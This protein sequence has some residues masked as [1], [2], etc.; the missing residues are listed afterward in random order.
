MK[1][2]VEAEAAV[3]LA[4]LFQLSASV[5]ALR[6]I[7]TSGRAPAWIL[8]ASALMAMALRRCISLYGIAFGTSVDNLNLGY[9]V[10]GLLISI[11]M[12]AGVLLI[13]P[14]FVSI[15]ETSA[16]LAN[17]E[18]KYRD[19]LESSL[20]GI[21]A[22]NPNNGELLEANR[23]FA[24]MV[25]CPPASLLGRNVFD[26]VE[27]FGR[28]PEDI[29]SRVMGEGKFRFGETVLKKADGSKLI[30][31]VSAVAVEEEEGSIVYA[32]LH[33]LTER[34][35]AEEA[36][37]KLIGQLKDALSNVKRLSGLLPICA[38]CKKIR[39]DKGYWRQ[40]EQYIAEHSE[41]DFTHGLCPQCIKELYSDLDKGGLN[42]RSPNSSGEV[43]DKEA[44][45]SSE[46]GFSVG[47]RGPTRD[48]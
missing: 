8:I 25:G 30:I 16:R 27:L 48:K 11:L 41:A 44:E 19:V 17:S 38:S 37:N 3:L 31:D 2:H 35:I 39:D 22:F 18:R 33:D 10:I 32:V 28:K 26:F 7:K 40:I 13:K 23:Y 21:I 36:R 24:N 14:I 6:L 47:N 45:H 4:V 12:F 43:K 5:L 20:E 34:K 9:E 46:A 1:I 15:K 29:V 42:K